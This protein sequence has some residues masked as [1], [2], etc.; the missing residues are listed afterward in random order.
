MPRPAGHHRCQ[1]RREKQDLP[2]SA[3]DVQGM[4]DFVKPYL[5]SNSPMLEQAVHWMN[6]YQREA[7]FE[8]LCALGVPISPGM[9]AGLIRGHA[10]MLNVDAAH[11]A[12][13]KWTE[14]GVP[15][16]IEVWKALACSHVHQPNPQARLG[17][18]AWLL[19]QVA[20]Q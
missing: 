15:T 3:G 13:E 18:H 1:S 17:K 14:R 12:F 2:L 16:T 4:L 19:M 6:K 5:P 10:A 11:R 7:F 9:L 8:A 20:P